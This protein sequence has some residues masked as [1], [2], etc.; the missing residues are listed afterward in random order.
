MLLQIFAL[1]GWL[2]AAVVAISVLYGNY[3]SLHGGYI[4]D[5]PA[6]VIYA[7]LSRF[8]WSVVLSWIVFACKYGYGGKYESVSSLVKRMLTR[9]Q[10]H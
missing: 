3:P 5:T 9:C 7:I 6:N 10:K 8:A 4:P 2:L 1:F